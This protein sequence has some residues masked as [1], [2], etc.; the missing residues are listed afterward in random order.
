MKKQLLAFLTVLAIALPACADMN[1]DFRDH[2]TSTGLA[3][4]NRDIAVLFGQADFHTGEGVAFPG[5][6]IGAILTAVKTSNDS[7]TSMSYFYAPFITAET[8]LPIFNLGV[9]LRGTSY[10]GFTSFGGGIK[11]HETVAI[12]N[13]A[14]GLYYDRYDTDYYDGNHYSASASAS[15]DLLIFTPYI[16]IGYDASNL[17]VKNMGVASGTK[18][19]DDVVRYTAGVNVHP[20]PFI[21]M[22]GAYTYSKYNHGFQGGLGLSF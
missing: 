6:D 20:I 18:S 19:D 22:Y 2:F 16:G 17:K 7:F 13:L 9:A 15:T 4:Y 21:Y 14:A 5:I 8:E 12:I 11:W 1:S 3:A 10:N